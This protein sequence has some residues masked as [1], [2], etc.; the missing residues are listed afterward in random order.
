MATGADRIACMRMATEAER[1]ASI[2]AYI[3]RCREVEPED[4]SGMTE[5]ERA[6][7]AE[8][9]RHKALEE[10]RRLQMEGHPRG[11]A[12]EAL[13]RILDF[14]PKQEEGVYYNRIYFVDHATFDLDEES[15]LGPMRYT[16]RVSKPGEKP[17]SP[18]AAVNIFSV[19]I[20]SSDVGFPIHVYGTVI[21]RDS[22]DQKC[23]YLFRRHRD[24]CQLIN[25]KDESLI[26]TGPKRGLA[27]ISDNFVEI[28]LKIKDHR[29]QDRELSKGILTIRGIAGRWLGKRVVESESLATRLSTV[30]VMYAVVKCAMEANIVIE[31]VRGD[32]DGKITA[33]TTNIQNSLVL[34]DSEV[35]GAVTSDGN[36]VIQLMRP[37]VSVYVK[38][39]LK[40]V[41]ETGD[42][43]S[44]TIEFT[45]RVNYGEEDV[46][47]VG[48]TKMRVK[49]T[50]SIMDF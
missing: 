27:L 13:A 24:H 50:W 44:C 28:D 23:L 36:G 47:T 16:D 33:H 4:F 38:D 43:K 3:Q 48:V 5:A 21:A 8:K 26:L 40:I 49:V 12:L 29:G 31:V 20:G 45:P 39:M 25:S 30:D 9:R 35:A 18:C 7:E 32:F 11:R 6:A 2:K 42:G 34:Y 10:A 17:Y 37:V 19:K 41:A 1:L 15:P 46:I 22:I 14:D